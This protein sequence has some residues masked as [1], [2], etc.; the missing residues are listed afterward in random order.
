MKRARVPVRLIGTIVGAMVTFVAIMSAIGTQASCASSYDPN[1]TT[2]IVAPDYEIYKTYLDD[3]LDR[4]CGT[5]DCHGAPGR[6]YRMFGSKGLRLPTGTLFDVALVSGVQPTTEAEK[7]ANYEGIIALEPEEMS[8]VIARNGENPLSLE[9][10]RKPLG[11]ETGQPAPGTRAIGERHKGGQVLDESDPGYRCIVAW[12]QYPV[13]LLPLDGAIPRDTG[14]D[15][16]DAGIIDAGATGD[17][18]TP[19]SPDIEKYCTQLPNYK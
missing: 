18:S 9:F 8:R 14:I 6:A 3:F 4:R 1:K 11:T 12:L 7:R 2:A 15:T 16:G 13:K 5:L 19:L 17:G 10:L